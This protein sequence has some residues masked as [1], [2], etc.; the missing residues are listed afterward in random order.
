MSDAP[1]TI[2]SKSNWLRGTF[3][4]YTR[5]DTLGWR[6]I[7]TARDSL[8]DSQSRLVWCPERKNTYIVT[9]YAGE[10]DGLE[11]WSIFGQNTGLLT[12]TPS[13]WQPLPP[14]PV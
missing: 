10:Q 13:L 14:P 9:W 7:E 12:E 4:K 1:E 6:D 2:W 8:R 11:G 3:T 5:T